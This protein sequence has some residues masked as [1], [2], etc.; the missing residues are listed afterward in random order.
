MLGCEV[1]PDMLSEAASTA[2]APAS[3]QATIEATPVPAESAICQYAVLKSLHQVL[4]MS[5]H[6]NWKVRVLFANS[7]DQDSGCLGFE[8]SSLIED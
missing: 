7:T 8:H 2:S 1:M 5:M 3:A 6:M 4:T